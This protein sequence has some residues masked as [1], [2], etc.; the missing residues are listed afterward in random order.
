MQDIIT[1]DQVELPVI[2]YKDLRVV[3]TELLAKLFGAKTIQIQQNHANNKI[4]FVEGKH[5]F[6][7]VGQELKEFVTRF[8]LVA[9]FSKVRSLILWTERGAARHAKILETDAAWNV[10]EK[11][12]QYP[13]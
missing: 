9:N 8:N 10:F 3:T 2:V 13:H 1:I 5:Y 4:R 11:L 7:I 12:E 6:K